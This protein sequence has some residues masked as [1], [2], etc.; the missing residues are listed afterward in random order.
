MIILKSHKNK[1]T[2]LKLSFWEDVSLLIREASSVPK[3]WLKEADIYLAG[4]KDNNKRRGG[5]GKETE[6][7][8]RMVTPRESLT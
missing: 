8:H 1:A 4:E 3:D 7:H 6:T 2:G 5:V